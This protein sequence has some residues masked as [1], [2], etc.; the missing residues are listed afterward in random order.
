MLA[1]YTKISCDSRSKLGLKS[2]FLPNCRN[3]LPSKVNLFTHLTGPVKPKQ[4]RSVH[5]QSNHIRQVSFY[6]LL[7]RYRLPWPHTCCHDM[8]TSLMV[9]M[10]SYLKGKTVHLVNPTAPFLLTRVG[11]LVRVKQNNKKTRKNPRGEKASTTR[12]LVNYQQTIPLVV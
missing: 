6:A 8:I 11:P 4:I 2:S 3:T 10:I 1:T 7:R 12:T 5:F 9:S